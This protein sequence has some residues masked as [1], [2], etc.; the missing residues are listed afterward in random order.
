MSSAILFAGGSPAKLLKIM[1]HM[2]VPISGYATFMTPQKKYLHP[3]VRT[4]KN[5]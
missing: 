3:A 1:R 5:V 2:N 4:F